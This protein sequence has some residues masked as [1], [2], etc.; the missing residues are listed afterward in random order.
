M[1]TLK[2]M[3]LFI[4]N[5]FSIILTMIL[6][7]G[8]AWY[9][10][11]KVKET[12]LGNFILKIVTEKSLFWFVLV[13]AILLVLFTALNII[14]NRKANSKYLNFFIHVN[15]WL[16]CILSALF[17]IAT[18]ALVNPLITTGIIIDVSKKIVIG[19]DI[20]ILLIFHLFSGKISK[21]IN[22]K[23]QSYDNAKEMSVVGRSSIVW[24][25]IL[26]LVEIIFPE[27]LV[28]ILLCVMLSWDVA[29]YFTIL[30]ISCIIPVIGNIVCDLNTRK[31]IERK[32][33]ADHNKLVSDVAI[34]VKEGRK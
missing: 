4:M 11:P 9:C 26:K 34:R 25:N 5:I 30:L 1:K 33:E 2:S 13:S 17:A 19:T 18:F 8:I 6:S 21:I 7:T 12:I 14:F 27:I 24:V 31:E 32:N 29:G 10:L 22:R 23:I 20:L 3:L 16:W 15:S 28:L